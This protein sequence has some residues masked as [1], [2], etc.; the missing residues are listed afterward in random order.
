MVPVAIST[1][2]DESSDSKESKES[3]LQ[4]VTVSWDHQVKLWD[5][6]T[7]K[8]GEIATDA[9]IDR[10]RGWWAKRDDQSGEERTT[11]LKFQESSILQLVAWG[12]KRKTF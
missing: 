10:A 12:V 5:L 9:G 6:K 2:K 3:P 11:S 4:F 8:L 1:S 7:M